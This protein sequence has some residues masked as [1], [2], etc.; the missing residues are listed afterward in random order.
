[1]SRLVLT[2]QHGRTVQVGDALVEVRFARRG[3]ARLIIV[4]PA[5]VPV[6]LLRPDGSGEG[7]PSTP[8]SAAEELEPYRDEDIPF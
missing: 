3:A 8:P 2:V 4:A 6:R 5:E 7:A 1:M